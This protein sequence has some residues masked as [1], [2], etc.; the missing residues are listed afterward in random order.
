ME[1]RRRLKKRTGIAALVAV[2][3][4]LLLLPQ[5]S[6][7]AVVWSDDFSGGFSAWTVAEGDWRVTDGYLESYYVSSVDSQIWHASNQTVGTWSFDVLVFDMSSDSRLEV[8]YMFMVNGTGPPSDYYGYGIRFSGRGTVYLVRQAG[9]FNSQV[10]L[11]FIVNEDILGTWTHVDVTRN[12]TGT[13]NVFLNAT[14]T[15]MQPNITATDTTYNYSERFV[16]YGTTTCRLDD[17][18][19]N[20]EILITEPEPEPTT[21][22]GEEST[23]STT[24]GSN[25]GTD[26]GSGNITLIIAGAGVGV[27]VLVVAVVL[28]KRR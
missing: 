17:V 7:A 16:V 11:R 12:A 19:V 1:E 13:F 24:S 22:T 21:T 3:G 25:T 23:S 6:M 20:S 2:F 9:G 26:T 4:L 15:T 10:S 27:V 8:D 5:Q 18:S 14:S 28:I